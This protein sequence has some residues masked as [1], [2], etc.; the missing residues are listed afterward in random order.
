VTRQFVGSSPD[1][2]LVAGL[3]F[4]GLAAVVGQFIGGLLGSTLHRIVPP[5]LGL[6]LADRVAG[7]GLGLLGVLVVVWLVAPVIGAAPG[8]PAETARGSAIVRGIY[9]AAPRAPGAVQSVA[10]MVGDAPLPEVFERLSTPSIPDPPG[11][12]IDPQVASRL[13]AS[14]VRVEG[15][16]CGVTQRGSGFVVG[17]GVVIT[18]AH[19]VAG[20]RAVSVFTLDGTR[21]DATVVAFDPRADVAVLRA[22]VGA[23]PLAFA[24][25]VVGTAG[26]AFGL[27]AD[28]GL[29]ELPASVERVLT[30]TGSDITRRISVT[31]RILVVATRATVDDVGGPVVDGTGSAVG[32]LF[33][34]DPADAR[35]GYVLVPAELEA[36]LGPVLAGSGSNTGVSTGGCLV[37]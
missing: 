8:F 27:R 9:E 6:R 23:T 18:T 30:P 7:A 37:G 19:A 3:V 14:V 17:D 2:R 33:A 11:N 32:M 13:A 4:M 10:L 28:T 35:V 31:R 1:T 29:A 25:A 21:A 36:A 20:V 24:D 26:S 34:V 15:G 16:A 22:A 5:G 12:G